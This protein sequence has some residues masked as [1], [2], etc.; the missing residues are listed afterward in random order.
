[1]S[2]RQLGK[3]R[4]VSETTLRRAKRNMDNPEHWALFSP[5]EA[6]GKARHWPY[7]PPDP[8]I[9]TPQGALIWTL[10]FGWQTVLAPGI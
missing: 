4:G 8:R 6:K 2:H 10:L 3:Q 5:P 1:M 7:V 9:S